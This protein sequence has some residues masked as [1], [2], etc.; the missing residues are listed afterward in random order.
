MQE[1]PDGPAGHLTIQFLIW[2]SE[3]PR[4]YGE[5]MEAWR[6]SCPRLSIWEDAIRDDLIRIEN[7]REPM[8]E[9]IVKLTGRGSALLQ[10][11]NQPIDGLSPERRKAAR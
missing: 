5:A 8:R 2:L 11:Y 6:T 3:A 1:I 9:A 4:T 10:R 7:D